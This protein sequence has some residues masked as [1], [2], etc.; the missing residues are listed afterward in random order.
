MKTIFLFFTFCSLFLPEMGISQQDTSITFGDENFDA[1][2]FFGF[3]LI[4]NANGGLYH[5]VLIKPE[6]NGTY[7]IKQI[8]KETFIAQAKGKE[9][10]TANPKGIDLFKKFQ[11]ENPNI[12]DDLWRLRYKDYPYGPNPKNPNKSKSVIDPGWSKND[13]IPFLP[14]PTQLKTLENF[15]MFKMNDYIYGD[16]AFRLLQLMGKPEWV[17]LY[18]E[19]F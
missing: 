19:S 10:S 3:N 5:V 17:K 18:K 2:Y 16:N 13:S 15:G 11:I 12:I 1:E 8:T 6:K 4:P 7:K 14:S 9:T